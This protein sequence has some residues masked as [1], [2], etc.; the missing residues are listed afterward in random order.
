M[1]A[2]LSIIVPLRPGETSWTALVRDLA[3][4]PVGTELIFT[5]PRPPETSLPAAE[6][7]ATGVGR[8]LAWVRSPLGRASQLNAGARAATGRFLWFLHADSRLAADSYDALEHSL[9]EAPDALHYFDLAFL[10]D[11][12]ELM[13]LTTA[14]T[15]FRSRVLG[16]P[17]G[18]QGFCLAREV[19]WRAGGFDERAP[20]GEDHLLVW[21]AARVG[22]PLRGV[23]AR[24]LTSARKYREAG[25]AKTTLRHIWLTYRQALP[26]WIK[27]KTLHS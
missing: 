2:R 4:L 18:D 7:N 13:R 11:G 24:L 1:A 25:W 16:M 3:Q 23:G 10:G 9:A 5:G 20:Y 27:T 22:I 12:P 26:E 6:W 17:F 14:G 19:F 15:W 21:Q 8:R